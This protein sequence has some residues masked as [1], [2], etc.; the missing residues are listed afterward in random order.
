MDEQHWHI[1]RL[2]LTCTAW[3]FTQGWK[4]WDTTRATPSNQFGHRHEAERLVASGKPNPGAW[5]ATWCRCATVR[6][7]AR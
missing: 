6:P 1:W 3:L 2:G 7:S 5:A 4:I